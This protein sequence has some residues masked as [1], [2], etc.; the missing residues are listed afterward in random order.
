VIIAVDEEAGR[1]IF[2]E[3]SAREDRV[4]AD[5]LELG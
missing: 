3:L 4:R 2:H 5:P 1:L